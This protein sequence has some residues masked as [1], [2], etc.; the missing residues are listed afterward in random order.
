MLAAG[1]F[2]PSRESLWEVFFL[3]RP[4]LSLLCLDSSLSTL[5]GMSAEDSEAVSLPSFPAAF[6][7][8]TTL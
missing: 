4:C 5:S 7:L 3:H 6:A 1:S 2:I 8:C